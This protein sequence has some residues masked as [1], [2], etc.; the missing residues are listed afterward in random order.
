M[1]L[2]GE[3][4]WICLLCCNADVLFS[5]I[6]LHWVTAI[7]S[8]GDR[9]RSAERTEATGVIGSQLGEATT[10]HSRSGTMSSTRID[11]PRR[12][13]PF[14][15]GSKRV[16]PSLGPYPTSIHDPSWLYD[17]P[18]ASFDFPGSS[19]NRI[20]SIAEM[21]D[22]EQEFDIESGLKRH[23]STP[24]LFGASLEEIENISSPSSHRKGSNK[25]DPRSRKASTILEREVT[26]T[27][28]ERSV[29]S[30]SND[31]NSST[32]TTSLTGSPTPITS[33]THLL[34]ASTPSNLSL[35]SP[36]QPRKLSLFEALSTSP[37]RRHSTTP[38]NSTSASS[39]LSYLYHFQNEIRRH[40]YIHTSTSPTISSF[41][42]TTSLPTS[43]FQKQ[44]QPQQPPTSPMSYFS[45]PTQEPQT[46][47]VKTP[48]QQISPPPQ[49][50]PSP[51]PSRPGL[52]VGAW[53][54]QSQ[55]MLPTLGN[56]KEYD[57]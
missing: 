45:I 56:L 13:G 42:P 30:G 24:G 55:P 25:S 43:H 44:P 21:R 8:N 7:D 16:S 52:S 57:L 48:T 50:T 29:S 14:G 38:Q 36:I 46:F 39:R 32:N 3:K 53:I 27:D 40:S 28:S 22:M 35:T 51:P 34:N 20:H 15:N 10:L 31:S 2:D 41:T 33:S 5:V 54:S 1:I 49:P 12:Q 26:P 4:G 47:N 23:G 37:P 19:H 9:D 18:S 6:V 17:F 11:F